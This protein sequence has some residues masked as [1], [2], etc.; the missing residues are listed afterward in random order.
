MSFCTVPDCDRETHAGGLCFK[1]YMRV[2]RHGAVDGGRNGDGRV[3]S[4]HPLWEMWKSLLASGARNGIGVHPRWNEFWDFIADVGERPSDRHKMRRTDTKRPLGPDNWQWAAP[5]SEESQ[6]KGKN[7]YMR[8]WRLKRP[9]MNKHHDLMKR[10]GI[11]IEQYNEMYSVQKGL[12]RICGNPETAISRKTGRPLAL[13]VD[14]CH[15]AE[16]NGNMKIRGLLCGQCNT[17]LGSAKDDIQ[18]LES[19]ITYLKSHKH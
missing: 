4:A 5:I 18:R 10:F 8:E 7:E 2:R 17:L 9:E 16:K 6:L 12:C 15:A 13:S 19:A 14:H 11:S 3:K 1:H